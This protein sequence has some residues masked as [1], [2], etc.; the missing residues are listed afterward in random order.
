MR[1]STEMDID[2]FQLSLGT[3]QVIISFLGITLNA[4]V[5]R[6]LG[7]HHSNGY[8]L[9]VNFL[10]L[11]DMGKSVCI[12]VFAIDNFARHGKDEEESIGK[13]HEH[14]VFSFDTSLHVATSWLLVA[15]ARH[16]LR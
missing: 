7:I 1:N 3:L 16:R 10:C 4:Y 12:M 11:T 14:I 5:I 8:H 2:V 6:V 9:L 13:I 15:I